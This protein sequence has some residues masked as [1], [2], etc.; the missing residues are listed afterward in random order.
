MFRAAQQKELRLYA[1]CT[2]FFYTEKVDKRYQCQ[3][4]FPKQHD[5]PNDF[6]L[7]KPGFRRG[8]VPDWAISHAL[9]IAALLALFREETQPLVDDS[10]GSLCHSTE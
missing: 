3:K 9:R 4:W 1:M 5:L 8:R 2:A 6:S 7:M 10:C